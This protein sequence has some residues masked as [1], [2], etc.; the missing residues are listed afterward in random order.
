MEDGINDFFSE[1]LA[2]NSSGPLGINWSKENKEKLLKYLGYT[3]ISRY[4]PDLEEDCDVWIKKSDPP[5]SL[6]TSSNLDNVFQE[7]LQNLI[8][9]RL[10]K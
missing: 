5:G 3:S 9:K 10:I 2:P 6:G 1:I 7:E 8:L 4:D